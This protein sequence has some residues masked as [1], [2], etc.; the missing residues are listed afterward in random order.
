MLFKP[1]SFHQVQSVGPSA[2]AS[3]RDK[4]KGRFVIF[5]TGI[6]IS[7]CFGLQRDAPG[8]PA[9]H[10][11]FKKGPPPS[12]NFDL[13]FGRNEE[14]QLQQPLAYSELDCL[15]IP[16][17]R[18][19]RST[20]T[21]LY[22]MAFELS[23]APVPIATFGL[24][25]LSS[26]STTAFVPPPTASHSFCNPPAPQY[27]YRTALTDFSLVSR[28]RQTSTAS[29][30]GSLRV[31]R[32][33]ASLPSSL[34]FSQ[35]ATYCI[36]RFLS[37]DLRSPLHAS[38]GHITPGP[39][40]LRAIRLSPC[41]LI[42][43]N[44]T[45][46]L[47]LVHPIDHSTR[48]T[49]IYRAWNIR[50]VATE[51][52]LFEPSIPSD[53]NPPHNLLWPS[54]GNPEIPLPGAEQPKSRSSLVSTTLTPTNPGADFSSVDLR[55]LWVQEQFINN[56]TKPTRNHSSL[57]FALSLPSLLLVSRALPVTFVGASSLLY[58]F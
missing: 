8:V 19:L 52:R 5:V 44:R 14:P 7:V 53:N 39:Q 23:I 3:I 10:A 55:V 6:Q 15:F 1:Q 24:H 58:P 28:F 38:S 22:D 18:W 43:F 29:V 48:G 16:P 41:G 2:P 46:H 9:T 54:R 34:V 37:I 45:Y 12:A 30:N 11:P 42:T 32:R 40:S 31:C 56:P 17:I 50:A 57:C 4:E 25:I 51:K 13:T 27:S 49:K 21:A 47:G 20:S 35:T 36:A 33:P 26:S